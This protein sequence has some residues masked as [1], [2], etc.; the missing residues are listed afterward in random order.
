MGVQ[1]NSLRKPLFHWGFNG[2]PYENHYSTGFLKSF[3]HH[4]GLY[5]HQS[6]PYSSKNE[7]NILTVSKL[8]PNNRF[9]FRVISI[10]AKVYKTTFPKEFFNSIWLKLG[11]HEYIY[12]AEIRFEKFHS[13]AILGANHFFFLHPQANLC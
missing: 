9:S 4:I 3:P 10:L 5:L 12:I 7:Q 13:G 6:Q 11:D 1:W 8:R 2:T